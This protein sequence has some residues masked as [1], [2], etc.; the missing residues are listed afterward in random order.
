MFD[1]TFLSALNGLYIV[2]ANANDN[3][4]PC[5]A[6]EIRLPVW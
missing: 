3:N 4:A 6:V 2:D 1:L 5:G